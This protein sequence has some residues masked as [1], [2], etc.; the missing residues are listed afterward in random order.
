MEDY[1]KDIFSHGLMDPHV[2]PTVGLS[3]YQANLTAPALS[4]VPNAK[5]IQL[6]LKERG[7]TKFS[8]SREEAPYAYFSITM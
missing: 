4:F 2:A 3:A 8:S 7:M 1:E 5:V 6:F